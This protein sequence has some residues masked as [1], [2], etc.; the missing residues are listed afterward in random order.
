MPG[1]VFKCLGIPSKVAEVA[2]CAAGRRRR[3]FR[4][5]RA[6]VEAARNGDSI[7]LQRGTHNGMG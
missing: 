2:G 6:A 4:S 1:S 5:L 7:V 3:S